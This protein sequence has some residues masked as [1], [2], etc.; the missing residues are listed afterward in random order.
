M[1]FEVAVA[2]A[3]V[4]AVVLIVEHAVNTDVLD[5]VDVT[6]VVWLEEEEL[7]VELV[8]D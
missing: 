1:G 7:K 8:D 2:L 5:V 4:V 6:S 3:L